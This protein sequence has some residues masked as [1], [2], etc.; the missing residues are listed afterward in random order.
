MGVGLIPAYVYAFGYNSSISFYLILTFNVCGSAGKLLTS[1]IAEMVGRYNTLLFTTI[2]TLFTMI[3]IWLPFGPRSSPMLYIAVAFFGFGTGSF[4]SLTMACTGHIC[5]LRGDSASLGRWI[6]SMDRVVAGVT[7]V[8]M[9]MSASLIQNYGATA[10]V[11]F[12]VGILALSIGAVVVSRKKC[13]ADWKW[14]RAV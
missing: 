9:P 7:L 14:R 6:A 4:V 3:V 11:G 2:V 13:G 10:M 1:F 5:S 12:S 8:A